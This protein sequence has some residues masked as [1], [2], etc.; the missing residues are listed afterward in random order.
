MSVNDFVKSIRLK[1][2]AQLLLE[3]TLTINEV[4][5]TV[6]FND[7]KYFSREFKK[8]YGVNPKDYVSNNNSTPA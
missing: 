3:K 8:Q 2:G 4:S 6:G 1:K 5:F 7:R